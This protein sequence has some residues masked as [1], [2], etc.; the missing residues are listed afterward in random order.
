MIW[1][2]AHYSLFMYLCIYDSKTFFGAYNYSQSIPRLIQWSILVKINKFFSGPSTRILLSP[3]LSSYMTCRRPEPT[4]QKNCWPAE[5]LSVS[6]VEL[7]RGAWC[8]YFN[9]NWWF[10]PVCNIRELIHMVGCSDALNRVQTRVGHLFG[11]TSHASFL[12]L[13][14]IG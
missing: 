6:V 10:I 14:C 9:L 2:M 8:L 12:N 7:C 11:G 3:I 5:Q 13:Y 4:N 1:R